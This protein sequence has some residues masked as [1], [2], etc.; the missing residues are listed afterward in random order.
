[1]VTASHSDTK[2]SGKKT[3]TFCSIKLFN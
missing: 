2:N 3:A 1:V